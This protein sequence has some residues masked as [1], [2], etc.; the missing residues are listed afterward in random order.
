MAALP[1]GFL[2]CCPNTLRFLKICTY[3]SWSSQSSSFSVSLPFYTIFCRPEQSISVIELITH[4]PSNADITTQGFSFLICS[5]WEVGQLR[6]S[7]KP[8]PGLK[9]YN[10]KVWKEGEAGWERGAGEERER[11][12][13]R[14]GEYPFYFPTPSSLIAPYSL[15]AT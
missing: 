13:G 8:L 3:D 9:F 7:I 15:H 1:S 6:T 12:G 2:P 4:W 10:P 14:T 11:G 5:V